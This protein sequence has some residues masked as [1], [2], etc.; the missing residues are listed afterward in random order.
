MTS[1]TSGPTSATPLARFDQNS[2]SWRTCE[3]TCLLGSTPFSGKWPAWG[4]TH[5]GELYELP[6]PEPLTSAPESS[7]L[8]TPTARDHKDSTMSDGVLR[9]GKRGKLPGAIG[10]LKTPH[11]GLGE[12]GRDGVIH[13]PKGQQDLQHQLATLLLPIPVADNSR[14]LPQP[15]T[16]YSSL[17]NAVLDLLPTPEA[18]DGGRGRDLAR[19]RPDHK[20]R[21]LSTTVAFVGEGTPPPLTAGSA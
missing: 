6:T 18:G 8:P 10:L 20:S 15:G 21:E 9:G 4:M 19:P 5:G 16:A 2:S 14:G 11:A 13:N 1:D 7:S 17:P 3:D 12:R